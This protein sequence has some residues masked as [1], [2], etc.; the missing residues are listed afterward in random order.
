[1]LVGH[2]MEVLGLGSVNNV[3]ICLPAFIMLETKA[4]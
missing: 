2:G 1:M 4:F 3:E